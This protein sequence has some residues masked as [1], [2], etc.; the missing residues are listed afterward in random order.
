[1]RPSSPLFSVVRNERASSPSNRY[2]CNHTTYWIQFGVD[3]VA[4]KA[5]HIALLKSNELKRYVEYLRRLNKYNYILV[6]DRVEALERVNVVIQYQKPTTID[7]TRLP[8]GVTIREAPL[9]SHYD[10]VV[11]TLK[12]ETEVIEEGGVINYELITERMDKAKAVQVA[13]STS[14]IFNQ[15]L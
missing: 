6:T 3:D 8:V 12:V 4:D 7:T 2:G 15:R 1:M 5:T 10:A 14:P 11:H 13:R 9:H